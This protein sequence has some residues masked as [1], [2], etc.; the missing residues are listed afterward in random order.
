M[1]S[2]VLMRRRDACHDGRSEWGVVEWEERKKK[3]KSENRAGNVFMAGN[4]GA[5]I[6]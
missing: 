4:E 6:R 1:R 3:T 2:H 5:R